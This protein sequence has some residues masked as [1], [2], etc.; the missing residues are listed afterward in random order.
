[1]RGGANHA[2]VLRANSLCRQKAVAKKSQIFSVPAT[3]VKLDTGDTCVHEVLG[4]L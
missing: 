2:T 4:L 1:M 3:V